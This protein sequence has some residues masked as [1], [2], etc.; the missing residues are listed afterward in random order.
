[1]EYQWI[2]ASIY[3][4]RSRQAGKQLLQP[5]GFD[6]MHMIDPSVE[7]GVLGVGLIRRETNPS[8]LKTTLAT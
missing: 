4:D 6:D 3:S 2:V 7:C 5:N 1:M 8:I